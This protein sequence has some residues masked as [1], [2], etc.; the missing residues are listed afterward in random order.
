VVVPFADRHA[1]KVAYSVGVVTTFGTE[2]QQFLVSYQ[3][4]FR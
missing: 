1:I 2:F 4:L 3:L